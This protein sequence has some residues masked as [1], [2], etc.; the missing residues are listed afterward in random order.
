MPL[1]KLLGHYKILKVLVVHSDLA[2][3]LRTFHK[4]PPLL[5]CSHNC[6]HLLVVDFVIP[7]YWRKGFERNV[8]GCHLLS[9]GDCWDNTALVA[10]SE[11]SASIQNGR[12]LSGKA[13]IGAVVIRSLSELNADCSSAPHLHSVSFRVRLNRGWAK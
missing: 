5:Q 1:V 10:K 2:V 4:I 3:M 8:M 11:L 9:S 6:Q 13:R 12:K 7:L